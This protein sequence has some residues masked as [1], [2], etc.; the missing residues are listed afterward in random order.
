ME[1]EMNFPR[2]GRVL[3]VTKTAI[4]ILERRNVDMDLIISEQVRRKLDEAT[5]KKLEQQEKQEAMGQ[6]MGK[7]DPNKRPQ[8]GSFADGLSKGEPPNGQ[9]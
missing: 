5:A 9:A 2:I 1:M 3:D 6:S 4:D 7:I 8:D